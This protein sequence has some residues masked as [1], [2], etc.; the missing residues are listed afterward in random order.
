VDAYSDESAA[1]KEWIVT[2]RTSQ[3]LTALPVHGSPARAAVDGVTVGR[4]LEKRRTFLPSDLAA[5]PSAGFTDDFTCLEGWSVPALRWEGVRLATLLEAAGED[6][7]CIE[8]SARQYSTL[9]SREEAN[10]ALLALWLNDAPIPVEHG[11]PVRLIVPGRECYTS[12]KWVDRITVHD[13][14]VS[15]A[16]RALADSMARARQRSGASQ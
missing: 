10:R 12:V 6:G 8:V 2:E 1:R 11:G 14:A 16:A 9:L 4:L 7:E 15:G 13:A 5:L 3:V